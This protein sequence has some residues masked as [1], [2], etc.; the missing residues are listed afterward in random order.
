MN[1]ETPGFFTSEFWLKLLAGAAIAFLTWFTVSGGALDQI[2]ALLTQS[3]NPLLVFV[4][5]LA[6]AAVFGFC[7]WALQ[8]LAE[9]YAAGRTLL[10]TTVLQLRARATA[11]L[12]KKA[13]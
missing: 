8:K 1:P 5:P 2:A 6:K 4:V 11:E 9:K 13:A 3:G 10:K 7:A 12:E